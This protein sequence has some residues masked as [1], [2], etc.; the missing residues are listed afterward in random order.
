MASGNSSSIIFLESR[1]AEHTA[2][3]LL[4]EIP[5]WDI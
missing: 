2:E 3:I 5:E 4:S 1:E